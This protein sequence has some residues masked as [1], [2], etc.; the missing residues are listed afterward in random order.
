MNNLYC[1]FCSDILTEKNPFIRYTC[2]CSNIDTSFYF[3][4]NSHSLYLIGYKFDWNSFI[5][6]DI[7]MRNIHVFNYAIPTSTSGKMITISLIPILPKDARSFY[8][9]I[10]ANKAF[11]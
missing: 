6:M 9:K 2:N 7:K 8:N 3:D 5:H 1:P 4:V 10:L 11:L